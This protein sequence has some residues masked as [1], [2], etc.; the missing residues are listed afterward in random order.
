MKI[1]RAAVLGAGVMGA[2]I[3]AHLAAAGVRVYLL[4]LPTEQ[5][6]TDPK[7][8]KIVGKNVRNTRSI[9]AIAALH[10][11]KPSPLMWA[12]VTEAI[13]PGNF[14]DDWSVLADADWIIEAV[15]EKLDI[16]R[17]IHQRIAEVAKPH[18]PVTT[19]TSG[20]L[21]RDIA[22]NLSDEY[23][24]RFF[25]VHFFNP[26]RYMRLVEVIAHPT[27]DTKLVASLSNWIEER[28]GKG[29]VPAGDH[30][31]FIA[32]RIGVFALMDVVRQ[33]QIANLDVATVDAL[34]GPLIGRAK[35]A[36]FRTVDVVG[37]DTFAHVA[38]NVTDKIKDDPY[39]DTLKIPDWMQEMIAG[40]FL[41][42]K[43]KLGGFYQKSKSADGKTVFLTFD[44]TSKKYREKEADDIPWVKDALAIKSLPDRLKFIFSKDDRYAQ[45]VR[46]TMRNVSSYA[47]L[48]VETI[49]DGRPRSL[50]NAV[51]WGFNWE[52]GPFEIWQAVGLKLD[53]AS[54]W[55]A[56]AKAEMKFYD[57][58]AQKDLHLPSLKWIHQPHPQGLP[59]RATSEDPR[60]IIGNKSASLVDIGD[61]V[62][63]LVFHSKMNTLNDEIIEM[64]AKT[65]AK[66]D[67]QF[68]GLVIANDGEH[69]SAGANL[70]SVLQAIDQG[71]F[72]AIDR[73]IRHL[74]AGLQLIKF[75][76]FPTVSAPY[77]LTLG[78]GCEV[79]L[80]ARQILIAA[81][82][83]AG[84]VEIGVG[85]L[86]AGGGTKELALRA[87][88][89]AS[90]GENADPMPFLQ[91]AFGLIGMA[92]TSSSGHEAIHMGLYP[93][94]TRVAMS[95]DHQTALAK[96]M[97]LA[98]LPYAPL[99]PKQGIKVPGDSGVQT[100]KMVLYNMQQGKMISAYDAVIGGMI[101]TVLC[102]GEVDAGTIVGEQ[103]FLDLERQC[104]VE[105]CRRPETRARIDHMLKTGKPLRN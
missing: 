88:E 61:D 47:A 41:G 51:K 62:A 104:F 55:P 20:I 42:Q 35:S 89:L 105:L 1:R 94:E 81:E 40:G 60:L 90:Q 38:R 24:S 3:A 36:T 45:F 77:G 11:L 39:F 33:M 8:A 32:N 76:P 58:V 18:V 12:Q 49:A 74:Q 98:Q 66:V 70:A 99:M 22:Q 2:Q 80:H 95:R 28:L 52:A 68:A 57:D 14:E 91:R 87:Y 59:K 34:T 44:P 26:P 73:M 103:H 29:I 82:C 23:Q 84:L 19:N 16:K 102:G 64:L 25:G 31:N 9:A 21:L 4:D 56:W 78:G 13:I 46:N 72:S 101:A 69:F 93:R 71:D 30:I 67:Q 83:Y 65:V 92:K 7:L 6:P 15:I 43:S 48:L 50:D 100:I 97:V 85:L 5:P 17:S 79:S 27:V 53:A 96:K 54:K 10:D 63:C 37:L 75:A 86:P